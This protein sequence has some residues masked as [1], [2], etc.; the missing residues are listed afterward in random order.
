MCTAHIYVFNIVQLQVCRATVTKDGRKDTPEC[1]RSNQ[2]YVVLLADETHLAKEK[3][4]ADAEFYKSQREAE[5]NNVS[6][7]IQHYF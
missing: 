1:E 3:A 5:S 2:V 6:L 4:K 7:S